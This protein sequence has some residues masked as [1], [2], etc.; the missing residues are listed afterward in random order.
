MVGGWRIRH[1]G[2]DGREVHLHA[3]PGQRPVLGDNGL[4]DLVMSNPYLLRGGLGGTSRSAAGQVREYLNEQDEGRIVRQLSQRPVEGLRA[5]AAFL[6]A[7]S[8]CRENLPQADDA[9]FIDALR[10]Q[11]DTLEL[12]RRPGLEDILRTR[13]PVLKDQCACPYG[14]RDLRRSHNQA[15]PG[16]RPHSGN[17]VMLEYPH[18]L[19]EHRSADLESGH[20]VSLSAENVPDRPAALDD[21]SLKPLG[22]PLAKLPPFRDV[23]HR[24][25]VGH[26]VP[27]MYQTVPS[28]P[29]QPAAPDLASWPAREQ[30]RA[31]SAD[32]TRLFGCGSKVIFPKGQAAR[33]A[34]REHT[35]EGKP[36]GF[37]RAL[38]IWT[39]ETEP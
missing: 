7:A 33:G 4:G 12:E 37:S 28:S 6:L 21:L 23:S 34:G 10:C 30:G 29:A 35:V 2:P 18:C 13:V 5:D 19:A 3:V 20:E 39:M 8:L 17:T 36:L 16:T 22:D 15:A 11:L 32:R 38:A 9:S 24:Q 26:G 31:P 27:V 25:Q 14:R 1:P